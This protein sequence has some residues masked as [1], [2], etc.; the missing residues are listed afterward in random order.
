ML[1]RTNSDPESG[2]GIGDWIPNALA[3]EKSNL[4]CIRISIDFFSDY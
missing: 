2:P 3:L 1:T 4:E